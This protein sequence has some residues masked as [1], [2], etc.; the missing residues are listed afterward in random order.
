MLSAVAS[1]GQMAGPRYP[2][3]VVSLPV[4]MCHLALSAAWAAQK[5]LKYGGRRRDE[6]CK[7]FLSMTNSGPGYE[8]IEARTSS[9]CQ[10]WAAELAQFNLILKYSN[11]INETK[12]Y[13]RIIEYVDKLKTLTDNYIDIKL[14]AFCC[15]SWYT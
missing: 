11:R 6:I 1:G 8:T 14:L 2:H 13:L 4:L 9:V 7:H 3:N 10:C 15:R 5:A 12:L